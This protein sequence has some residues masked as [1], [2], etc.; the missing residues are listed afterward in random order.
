MRIELKNKDWD[1]LDSYIK[2]NREAGNVLFAQIY[3]PLKAFVFKYA[4]DWGLNTDCC[5]DIIT[6]S[7][8]RALEKVHF[9]SG[10]YPF[11]NY[12]IGFANNILKE[13]RRE[14]TKNQTKIISFYDISDSMLNAA[15]IP[16]D[17]LQ[18]IAEKET[19]DFAQKAFSMLKKDH[20]DILRLRL[21]NELK[22]KEIYELTGK[23]EASIDSMYRRAIT[24]LKKNYE[25]L[26]K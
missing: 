11:K 10:Y 22:V 17:P 8:K 6:E 4:Q 9:Y 3:L 2:G 25:I 16:S 23:S 20:Q 14:D 13:K 12:V 21:F 19:Q 1:L 24:A 5:A 7:M 18:I 26:E 15:D